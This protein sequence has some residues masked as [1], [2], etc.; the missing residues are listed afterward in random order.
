MHN[1]III[2]QAW[3][4]TEIFCLLYNVLVHTLMTHVAYGEGRLYK[5]GGMTNQWNKKNCHMYCYHT[6]EYNTGIMCTERL[7]RTSHILLLSLLVTSF[8][9]FTY[10]KT[11]IHE[12]LSL[13]QFCC[14]WSLLTCWN[15]MQCIHTRYYNIV[16]QS[17]MFNFNSMYSTVYALTSISQFLW[18]KEIKIA[19]T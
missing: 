18:I 4:I 3:W 5:Q 7:L 1:S 17:R 2:V 10:T 15:Y 12:K 19:V 6:V 13:E 14:K 11:W 8:G 9:L 16:I